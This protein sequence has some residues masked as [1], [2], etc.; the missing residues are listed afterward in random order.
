MKLSERLAAFEPTV[1]AQLEHPALRWARPLIVRRNLLGASVHTVAL[2]AAFGI[3]AGAIPGPLQVLSALGLCLTFRANVVAAVAASFWTN[4]L[5]IVPIYALAYSIGSVVMPGDFA[6]VSLDGFSSLSP[7]G[8]LA[9]MSVWVQ[10]LGA[11][12]LVG[13]PLLTGCLA[14]A[15]YAALRIMMRFNL[16]K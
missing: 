9:D 1:L 13:L 15:V 16:E 5:T 8:W 12:L 3:L 10:Q 6:P 11:P 4:P 14:L 7:G 2:G